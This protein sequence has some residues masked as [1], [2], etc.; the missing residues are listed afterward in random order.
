MVIVPLLAVKVTLAEAGELVAEAKVI[1]VEVKALPK[2]YQAG[3][4]TLPIAKKAILQAIRALVALN[5]HTNLQ[6][7]QIHIVK[8]QV[9][10][11][12]H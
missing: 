5:R 11:F 8:S 12:N 1:L 7:H 4:A 3:K 10:V 2:E 9:E 6:D